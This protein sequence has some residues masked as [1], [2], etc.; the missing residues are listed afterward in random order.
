[1]AYKGQKTG[2]RHLLPISVHLHSL[3][4]LPV[5][6]G[7][8]S[9]CGN[10]PNTATMSESL[11]PLRLDVVW[12]DLSC[13]SNPR[14]HKAGHISTLTSD[15]FA[16]TESIH[17]IYLCWPPECSRCL[18][19]QGRDCSRGQ[20][21]VRNEMLC[22]LFIECHSSFLF[23]LCMAIFGSGF[24]TLWSLISCMMYIQVYIVI[25]SFPLL[26]HFW[27]LHPFSLFFSASLHRQAVVAFI[28]MCV[29]VFFHTVHCNLKNYVFN[30]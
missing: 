28:L 5:H 26:K 29:G 2:K 4:M 24:W 12:V 3:K 14:K 22:F 21:A 19:N 25:S 11:S 6:C 8:I 7:N 13:V 15:S 30:A 27:I 23:G 1:M 9:R 18:M 20:D 16:L 17:F 10:C